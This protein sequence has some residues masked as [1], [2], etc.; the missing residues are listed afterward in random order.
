MDKTKLVND[1][2]DTLLRDYG[3]SP[4]EATVNEM[5]NVVAKIIMNNISV[6]WNNSNKRFLNNRHAYYLSAEFLV[7]RA[8][9]NNLVCMG[10]FNDVK[11]ALNEIGFDI[12]EF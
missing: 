4:K 12:N 8:I 6:N 5:H 2:K 7:G 11:D 10:V 9:Q 3:K 1:I